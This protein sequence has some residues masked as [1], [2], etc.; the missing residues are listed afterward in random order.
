MAF[1]AFAMPQL[2][3]PE[4]VGVQMTAR[5]VGYPRLAPASVLLPRH[6]FEMIRI[7]AGPVEAEM[8]RLQSVGDRLHQSLVDET[9]SLLHP[10][11]FI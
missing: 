11:L 9:V 4:V 5:T 7:H 1:G 2:V 6:Q 3:G 8:V 10:P